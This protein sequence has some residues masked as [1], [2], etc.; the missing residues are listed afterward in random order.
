MWEAKL[1]RVLRVVASCLDCL[2]EKEALFINSLYRKVM[3]SIILK[4]LISWPPMA[5]II[6]PW[7]KAKVDHLMCIHPK[8]SHFISYLPSNITVAF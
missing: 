4:A 2:I 6:H 1:E 3:I 8:Q 7:Q 5:A